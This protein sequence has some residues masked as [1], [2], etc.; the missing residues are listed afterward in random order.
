M[1]RT[2]PIGTVGSCSPD[3]SRDR[4]ATRRS[5]EVIH[6]KRARSWIAECP[7]GASLHRVRCS[8]GSGSARVGSGFGAPGRCPRAPIWRHGAG[9]VRQSRAPRQAPRTVRRRL[10]PRAVG[11]VRRAR[12]LP[13]SASIRM[14]RVGD[15]GYVAIT[16][17]V[18]SACLGHRGLLLI[19]PDEQLLARLDDGGF[20]RYYYF[21]RAATGR[22]SQPGNH[23][24]GMARHRGRR[25]RMISVAPVPSHGRRIAAAATTASRLTRTGMHGYALVSFPLPAPPIRRAPR[26]GWTGR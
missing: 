12:V 11:S 4:S 1:A 26:S 9:G 15:R 23:R 8:N 13:A 24:R 21:G 20:S 6:A 7:R 3:V 10:E 25:A 5:R 2:L 17:C 14:L 19:G 18:T 22:R 16:G